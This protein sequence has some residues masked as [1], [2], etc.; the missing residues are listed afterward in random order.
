M[1]NA[2][3]AWLQ[4]TEHTADEGVVVRAETR[5]DLYARAAWAMFTLICD[6]EGVLRKDSLHVELE[7]PDAEALMVRWLS[8]LNVLHETR[9]MLFRDFEVRTATGTR[10]IADVYGERMDPRRHTLY[11]EIKA[12]TYHGLS[13]QEHNGTW[14]AEVLFDV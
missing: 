12:V 6:V 7:A 14:T 11:T 10:L 5:A 3:P 2:D 13:V 4:R 1:S 8:E 9:G